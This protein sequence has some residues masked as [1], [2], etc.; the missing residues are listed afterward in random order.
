MAAA[1]P[2]RHRRAGHRRLRP[3]RLRD[4]REAT[5]RF[6]WN[7]LAD[8]W[9]ELV[10][11]RVRHPDDHPA[12]A[13]AAAGATGREVLGAVVGLWAPF[14]PHVTEEIYQRLLRGEGAR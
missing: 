1:P 14:L 3:L 6:F 5:E 12:P 8:T 11:H 13:L 9:I 10:K 2:G 7:D 4:G